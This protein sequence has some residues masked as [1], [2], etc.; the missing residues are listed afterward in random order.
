MEPRLT[1]LQKTF[2]L[3][4]VPLVFELCF[5]GVLVYFQWQM[6]VEAAREVH[7]KSVVTLCNQLVR[8]F[9]AAGEKIGG[10]A[11]K[12]D[13]NS[14]TQF[15]K[16]IR[17]SR[18]S[19]A[20]LRDLLRDDP[21][22]VKLI[23]DVD[24]GL[25]TLL[26][27][28]N[29]DANSLRSGEARYGAYPRVRELA[30][31]LIERLG[32]D[33][34]EIVSRHKKIAAE[35]GSIEAGFRHK[36]TQ[37]LLLGVAINIIVAAFLA[38]K[39]GVGA[40]RRLRV[41]MENTNRMASGKQLLPPV[42]GTDEIAQLSR[43]FDQM[44]K[45]KQQVDEMKN[46]IV[47]MVSHDLRSPL[48][49]ISAVLDVIQ[50][51]GYGS[52]DARASSAIAA[53]QA[54]ADRMTILIND[55]LD[56]HA[57]QSIGIELVLGTTDVSKLLTESKLM[58]DGLAQQKG[59]TI[60]IEPT[61]LQVNADADR[62]GQVLANLLSNALKFSPRNSTITLGA[63]Q[64]NNEHVELF[65]KDEGRGVP[66]PDHERIFAKFEQVSTDDR[67]NH[68]GV[69]LG[70]AISKSIVELHGG[71]IGVKDNKPRGSIF[72]FTLPAAGNL[73]EPMESISGDELVTHTM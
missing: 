53:A 14:I 9:F 37:L 17:D 21:E 25:Q 6:E 63:A 5:V 1:F 33:F 50:A 11:M 22:E 51:G 59:V 48:A 12:I 34:F 54:N 20:Q 29:K 35:S 18:T 62:I 27:V 67:T 68:R 42:A 26:D 41:L 3:I 58:L 8:Q 38:W 16:G 71:S 45:S 70:L 40:N 52:M 73:P 61:T 69:G 19:T 46:E 49:S 43:T 32:R 44:A 2:L 15:E 4:A 24:A 66:E 65:V 31:P 64:A 47:A 30:T 23:D 36:V 56:A 10:F 60:C 28:S 7:A 57:M 39:F 72:W 55:L 13:D